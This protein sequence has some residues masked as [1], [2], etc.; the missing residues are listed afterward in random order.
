MIEET[1]PEEDRDWEAENDA[2]TLANAEQI[3]G[4][5]S[6]AIK[7]RNA[8]RRLSEKKEKESAA[9]DAVAGKRGD[10]AHAMDT[11]RGGIMGGLPISPYYR[12]K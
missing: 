6:R 1:S 4:D 12:K 10:I 8:A 11:R 5:P 7:A 9:M 2:E 3:K